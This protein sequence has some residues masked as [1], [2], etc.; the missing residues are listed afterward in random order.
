M[1]V[2][3]GD[4]VIDSEV[5]LR[6][7]RRSRSAAVTCRVDLVRR[8]PAR[9]RDW[10]Q[11]AGSEDL[12]VGR[13]EH[14]TVACLDGVADIGVSHDGSRIV[15]RPHDELSAATRSHLVLDIAV[16][17]RLAVLGRTVL[18]ATAVELDATVV[19]FS[20]PSGTGKSTMA[21]SWCAA[22]AA[23]V[24]DDCLELRRRGDG[25]LLA[26]PTYPGSRVRPDVAA[27]LSGPRGADAGAGKRFVVPAAMATRPAPLAAV[28]LLATAAPDAAVT[29]RPLGALEAFEA[30]RSQLFFADLDTPAGRRATLTGLADMVDHVTV[31]R[32]GVP[33]ALDRLDEVRRAVLGALRAQPASPGG[34][35]R[36]QRPGAAA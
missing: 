12:W 3:V 17:L 25:V 23:L 21:L 29:V 33:R 1:R 26:V 11:V 34:P 4:D 28:C 30:L 2:R 7:P 24:A 36:A 15:L 18:H 10:T 16:P 20:A 8:L 6:G 5:V 9:P 19:A 22:G 31:L 32:V 13:T 35:D 27:V 14:W